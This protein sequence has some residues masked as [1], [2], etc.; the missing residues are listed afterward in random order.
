MSEAEA[1]RVSERR[2][3]GSEVGDPDK[4]LLQVLRETA[5]AKE[6]AREQR[7]RE[8]RIGKNR[9]L[10]PE[11]VAFFESVDAE[12]AERERRAKREEEEAMLAFRNAQK[13]GGGGEAEEK[14]VRG[15]GAV[16]GP[17]LPGGG[18]EAGAGEPD[19]KQST[20]S[21]PSSAS[22]SVVPV[23][24]PPR[25]AFGAG[26][27]FGRLR[28]A[29]GARPAAKRPAEEAEASVAKR[30][31][32]GEAPEG[33]GPEPEEGGA[34]GLGSLLGGYGSSSDESDG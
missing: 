1:L 24:A 13:G 12:R 23:S 14:G 18:A 16:A 22:A 32:A 4:P 26:S 19:G 10:D 25:S 6:A 15:P 8:L 7:E 33:A 5:A 21:R 28:R 2:L 30:E 31:R 29:R 9:P 3:P 34:V 17:H 20:A 11:E 27:G